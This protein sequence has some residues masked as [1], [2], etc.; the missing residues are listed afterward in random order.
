[1]PLLS[2]RRAMSSGGTFTAMSTPPVRSSATRVVVSGNRAD[3]DAIP[4]RRAAPPARVLRQDDAV[5]FDPLLEDIGPGADRLLEELVLARLL[6][7]RLGQDAGAVADEG[8]QQQRI[9]PVG[10]DPQGRVVG[11]FDRFDPAELAGTDQLLVLLRPLD[12]E[13]DVLRGEFV[14]VMPV[15]VV[16][17]LHRPMDIVIAAPGEARRGVKRNW[18][19][20]KSLLTR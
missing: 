7:R 19:W 6:E 8:V 11:R 14:A 9:G 4:F 16:A 18:P 1:M 12:R 10:F 20:L 3:D 13:L 2:F 5:G 17:Q 15:D